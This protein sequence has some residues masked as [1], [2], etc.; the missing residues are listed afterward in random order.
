MSRRTWQRAQ[1]V[2]PRILRQMEAER[3]RREEEDRKRVLLQEINSL[4]GRLGGVG[5]EI[6]RLDSEASALETRSGDHPMAALALASLKAKI[7]ALETLLKNIPAPSLRAGSADLT[8]T[9]DRLVRLLADADTRVRAAKDYVPHVARL[10]AEARSEVTREE[11]EN[12]VFARART[13]GATGQAGTA[14]AKGPVAQAPAGGLPAEAPVVAGPEDTVP[15]VPHRVAATPVQAAEFARLA[16][17]AYDLISEVGSDLPPDLRPALDE[18]TRAVV[19]YEAKCES[20]PDYAMAQV[21]EV[22]RG[23]RQLARRSEASRAE[24]ETLQS[25]MTAA[26]DELEAVVAGWPG[27]S[28]PD[29]AGVAL[30][31][32]EVLR[33][34]LWPDASAV[35]RWCAETRTLAARLRERMVAEAE[36]RKIL[37]EAEAVLRELGYE[38][39]GAPAT[40]GLYLSPH[41]GGVVLEVGGDGSL[42]SEAVE[43]GESEA[44]AGE[45]T[46]IKAEL[47]SKQT[48]S[49]CGDYRLLT[50]RLA[51]RGIQL[52]EGG[53]DEED[54]EHLR[55]VG[56]SGEVRLRA[57]EK[58]SS[59]ADRPRHRR[60]EETGR[61]TGLT[62]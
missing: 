49:W 32:S 23:V 59:G 7:K 16:V 53:A 35:G 37:G 5:K 21:R 9:R 30:A 8:A 46:P 15:P 11:F 50:E 31:A 55:V 2:D 10:A 43:L 61:A 18:A 13:A 6:E 36:R 60:S 44:A 38:V 42:R 57:A 52:G 20:L 22:S 34:S 39:V 51:S 47:L 24:R 4:A 1:I 58:A 40:P 29:E 25:E 62:E 45:L 17:E 41:G 48:K 54:L 12:S 27:S 3:L 56:V 26:A 14:G 19:L 33:D 28:P